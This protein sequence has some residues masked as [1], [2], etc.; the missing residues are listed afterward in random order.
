MGVGVDVGVAVDEGVNIEVSVAV[1][2]SGSIVGVGVDS[3]WTTT[4]PLSKDTPRSCNIVSTS[5]S[6]NSLPVKGISNPDW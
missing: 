1:G 4:I 6:P 3:I 5:E 2:V